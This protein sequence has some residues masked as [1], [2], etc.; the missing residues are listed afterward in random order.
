MI[1][2]VS[3]ISVLVLSSEHG[4]ILTQQA[5]VRSAGMLLL[6]TATTEAWHRAGKFGE[7][8]LPFMRAGHPGAGYGGPQPLRFKSACILIAAPHGS[9]RRRM[10]D[11]GC[12][13]PD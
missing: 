9:I 6:R 1:A 11:R 13:R 4:G 3:C 7:L 10:A 12:R 2:V 8:I 5:W